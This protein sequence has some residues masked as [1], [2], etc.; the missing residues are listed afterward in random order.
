MWANLKTWP[1][2]PV[3]GSP[4]FKSGMDRSTCAEQLLPLNK[5]A[6]GVGQPFA[7]SENTM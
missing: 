2:T 1:A 5:G 3:N 4:T 7:L 6:A